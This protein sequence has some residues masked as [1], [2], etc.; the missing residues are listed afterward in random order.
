[1][2][3]LES[4]RYSLLG[5]LQQEH[6]S[7]QRDTESWA[8]FIQIYAPLFEEWSRRLQVPEQDRADVIQETLLKVLTKVGSF[9]RIEGSTFRGWLHTMLRNTWLDGV[10]RQK[11][12]ASFDSTVSTPTASDPHLKI[13]QEEYRQ[14]IIRRVF[15]L[16]IQ[17]F[18]PT[19]Q[20]AFRRYVIEGEPAS[21][22]ARDLGISV[23]SLYL[24]RS[25]IV[26]KL[27]A[28]L[29]EMLDS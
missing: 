16:L 8:R 24:I 3:S 12:H 17:E 29:V 6:A 27:Q 18:P 2:S 26:K 23:N 9:T 20:A 15:H 21:E 5:R 13:E 22:V 14:Y 25:R 10:R 4:T 28:E 19:T 7:G 11:H 1:M